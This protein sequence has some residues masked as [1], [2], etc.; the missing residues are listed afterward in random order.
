MTIAVAARRASLLLS[1]S[2]ALWAAGAAQAQ[3]VPTSDQDATAIVENLG[4]PSAPFY[5][6]KP[7]NANVYPRN[8]W[9][10]MAFQ[11]KL[12]IGNGNSSNYAPSPN[13][14]PAPIL[15]YDPVANAV[16]EEFL[17]ADEQVDVFRVI[18]GELVIPG[19]DPLGSWDWGNF[20]R[21]RNGA[22]SLT[23]T[24]PGGVHNF[25]MVSFGGALWAALGSKDGGAV[26]ES[27]DDGQTWTEYQTWNSNRAYSL[28]P[29]AGNLYASADAIDA[30]RGALLNQWTGTGFTRLTTSSVPGARAY[31]PESNA[32][33]LRNLVFAN[34]LVYIMAY[35]YN[36]QQSRPFKLY[37][38]PT[39]DAPVAV[40]LAAGEIPY[41]ITVSGDQLFAL[42]GT[43]NPA[44]GYTVQVRATSDLNAWPVVF[45]FTASTLPRSF[46]MLNGDFYIGLGADPDIASNAAV[47]SPDTGTL[48][49]VKGQLLVPPGPVTVNEPKMPALLKAN[50][51]QVH[52]EDVIKFNQAT[53]NVT[54]LN[55]SIEDGTGMAYLVSQIAI[56]P[57]K[58]G[59]NYKLVLDKSLHT[60]PS[61]GT[62]NLHTH[63]VDSPDKIL[64]DR[65]SK[66]TS[67]VK[68]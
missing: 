65:H 49:R 36:D 57:M 6:P 11:G 26:D 60:G 32:K 66:T 7:G 24:I 54:A 41:D 55:A 13:A 9:S 48:L 68:Y 35:Q 5:Q 25:D 58:A 59:T 42:T 44:G 4:I 40:P 12:Y 27:L 15:S 38:A 18:N 34:Q 17:T 37:T 16:T 20:Y 14:G 64:I 46:A 50:Y 1:A 29:F 30:P 62:L 45:Y 31:R 67:A 56:P 33:V 43:P 39:I 23:R 21:L 22:W 52:I 51:A 19:H 47:L 28:L 3:E 8:V 63:L 53:T 2:A 10:L 61:G